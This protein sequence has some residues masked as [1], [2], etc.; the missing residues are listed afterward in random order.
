MATSQ[1][2]RRTNDSLTVEEFANRF[3]FLSDGD[4]QRL[5][6]GEELLIDTTFGWVDQMNPQDP[7]Y[8][9][10]NIMPY[11]EIEILNDLAYQNEGGE[12]VVDY[13]ELSSSEITDATMSRS[14][15]GSFPSGVRTG[16]KVEAVIQLSE[17]EDGVEWLNVVEIH[18]MPA[19]DR[20]EKQEFTPE[21]VQ[22]EEAPSA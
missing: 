14:V 10:L 3:D 6:Q 1:N 11:E 19:P 12:L 2:T 9:Y 20:A 5:R 7:E 15:I 18:D 8:A 22:R 17:D 16:K 13:D 21:T 4:M